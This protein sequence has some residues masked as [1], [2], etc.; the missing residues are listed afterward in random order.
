MRRLVLFLLVTA[1]APLAVAGPAAAKKPSAATPGYALVGDAQLISPGN[2]SGT[3]VQASSDA[4]GASLTTGGI[5]FAVAQGM[6][7]SAVN[8]LSTDYEVVAGNCWDGSPRFTVGVAKGPT[9]REIYFYF[10]RQSNGTFACPTGPYTNTG[11]LAS[12]TSLVDTSQLPGG[13]EAETYAAAQATYGSYSVRY[14][15]IDVDGGGGGAQ[16]FDLD[17]SQVNNTLYTYEQP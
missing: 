5:G 14:I 13:S 6:K 9:T 11:N 15:A 17:N 10:G 8:T 12:P 4:S 16:T 1:T 7:L 3:A 2:D